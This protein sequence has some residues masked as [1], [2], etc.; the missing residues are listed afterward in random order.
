MCESSGE[1]VFNM[2]DVNRRNEIAAVHLSCMYMFDSDF[3][4]LA[5][6][7][8]KSFYFPSFGNVLSPYNIVYRWPCVQAISSSEL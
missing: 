6:N 1:G 8:P 4:A 7:P 3:Q 5:Q 2:E